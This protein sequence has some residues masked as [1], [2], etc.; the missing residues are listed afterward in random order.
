MGGAFF[1]A[2]DVDLGELGL[3]VAVDCPLL[4]LAKEVMRPWPSSLVIVT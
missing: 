1:A 4:E 3:R 2:A